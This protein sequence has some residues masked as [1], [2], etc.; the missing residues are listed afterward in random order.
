MKEDV[1]MEPFVMYPMERMDVESFHGHKG[2]H[3]HTTH[4][5]ISVYLG[6]PQVTPET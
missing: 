5:T 6:T 4:V 2:R 3:L 1:Q